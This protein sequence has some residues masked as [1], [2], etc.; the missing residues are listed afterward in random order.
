ML[1]AVHQLINSHSDPLGAT[2]VIGV[3]VDLESIQVDGHNPVTV[4]HSGQW[5]DQDPV[6]DYWIVVGTERS[7]LVTVEEQELH[8]LGGSTRAIT[9]GFTDVSC[10]PPC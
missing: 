4:W 7:V 3:V 9:S 1:E 10:G 2:D 6:T 8:D 5:M